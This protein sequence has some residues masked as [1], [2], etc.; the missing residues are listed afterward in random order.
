MA[1]NPQ[2]LL[3]SVASTSILAFH[4]VAFL[5]LKIGSFGNTPAVCR[6]CYVHPAGRDSYLKGTLKQS[7]AVEAITSEKDSPSVLKAEERAILALLEGLG[8]V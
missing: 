2:L 3:Q 5:P 8:R 1:L 7:L 4:S 6:K